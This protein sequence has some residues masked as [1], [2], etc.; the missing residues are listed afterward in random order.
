MVTLRD[1]PAKGAVL[2]LRRAPNWLRVVVGRKV[3]A[4]DQIEDAPEPDEVVYVYELVEGTR[5]VVFVRPGGRYAMGEYRYLPDVDG[6]ALRETDVW[7]QW[8][9]DRAGVPLQVVLDSIEAEQ[10]G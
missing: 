5:S 8:T 9:A 6:E 3:D 2:P 1:G 10:R 7:R 4:L